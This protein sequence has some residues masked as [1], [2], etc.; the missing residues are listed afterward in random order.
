MRV[1]I[2]LPNDLY[3]LLCNYCKENG[4]KVSTL[5]QHLIKEEINLKNRKELKEIDALADLMLKPDENFAKLKKVWETK[6]KFRILK[7]GLL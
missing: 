5:L 6:K 1:N 4:F 2:S 3:T 7:G